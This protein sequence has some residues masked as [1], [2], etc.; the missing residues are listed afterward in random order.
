MRSQPGSKAR[1]FLVVGSLVGLFCG[2]CSLYYRSSVATDTGPKPAGTTWSTASEQWAHVGEE[3]KF[4][5]GLPEGEA[6]YAVLKVEPTGEARVTDP[7]SP[8]KF[9]FA[10]RFDKPTPPGKPLTIRI[11]AYREHEHRDYMDM[12]GELLM[13]QSPYD[14]PDSAVALATIKLHVYQSKVSLTVPGRPAGYRWETGRLLLYT[15]KAEPTEVRQERFYRKG[16]K[17]VG[18]DESGNYLV[19]YEPTATQ[20]NRCGQTKVVLLVEDAG[21]KEHAFETVLET[22]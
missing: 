18:P 4:S 3:V 2:G 19:L 6:D 11:T 12:D 17:V 21:G 22:P 13:K 5:F 10:M 7:I 15:D 16:F 8:G 20:V 1:R 14:V 9:H